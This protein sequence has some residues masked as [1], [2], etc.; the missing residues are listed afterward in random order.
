VQN[1]ACIIFF[2]WIDG[3]VERPQ[4]TRLDGSI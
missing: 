1:H 4:W 2:P 3:I